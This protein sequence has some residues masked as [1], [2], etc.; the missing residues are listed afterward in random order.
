MTNATIK[1]TLLQLNYDRLLPGIYKNKGYEIKFADY[2]FLF[3]TYIG[4]D[5]GRFRYHIKHSQ[6]FSN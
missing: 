5:K 1:K 3:S 2:A 6:R 4:I